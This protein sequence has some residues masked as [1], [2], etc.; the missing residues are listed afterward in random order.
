MREP[1]PEMREYEDL[2]CREMAGRMML[3]V[4]LI[5]CAVSLS[6]CAYTR[7][8]PLISAPLINANGNTTTVPLVGQ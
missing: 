6:G 1:T 3:A 7:N 4:V 2:G 8:A 5:C